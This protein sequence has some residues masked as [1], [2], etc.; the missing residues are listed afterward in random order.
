M[1]ERLMG[2]I[3]MG[4]AITGCVYWH[5]PPGTHL[6][7]PITRQQYFNELELRVGHDDEVRVLGE[8]LVD[9]LT[10][11]LGGWESAELRKIVTYRER[12][13]PEGWLQRMINGYLEAYG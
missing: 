12:V 9:E 11:L 1:P 2:E 13:N 5:V 10:G 6:R 7:E 8:K 4:T 3:G